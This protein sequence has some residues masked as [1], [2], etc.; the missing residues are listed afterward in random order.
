MKSELL[1][2]LNH[3]RIA[4]LGAI[5]PSIR[6]I[7]IGYDVDRKRLLMRWYLDRLPNDDDFEEMEIVACEFGS[8]GPELNIKTFDIECVHSKDFIR[9]MD[10]LDGF[11]Y[12]R[13]EDFDA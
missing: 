11:L 8:S 7:A 1:P 9:D 6:A 10:P 13:K 12:H 2:V 3:F 5:Y 4:L